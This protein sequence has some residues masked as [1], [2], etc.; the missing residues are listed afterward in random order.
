MS[1]HTCHGR[2]IQLTTGQFTHTRR[3]DG[4]PETDGDFQKVVREKMFSRSVFVHENTKSWMSVWFISVWD[5]KKDFTMVSHCHVR[6]HCR[7]WHG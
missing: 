6:G 7:D 1:T 5:V 4:S 3:S 2:S